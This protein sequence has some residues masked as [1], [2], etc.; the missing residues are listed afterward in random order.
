[1]KLRQELAI[2]K[3]RT[4]HIVYVSYI[5]SLSKKFSC[6]CCTWFS[7]HLGIPFSRQHQNQIYCLLLSKHR[8][9]HYTAWSYKVMYTFSFL[10]DQALEYFRG[11][12]LSSS[13][14]HYVPVA[15]IELNLWKACPWSCLALNDIYSPGFLRSMVLFPPSAFPYNFYIHTLNLLFFLEVIALYKRVTPS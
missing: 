14:P 5:F 13:L 3:Q 11:A 1:M 12:H 9:S 7:F 15:G 4:G 2:E 8:H 6:S 10:Q